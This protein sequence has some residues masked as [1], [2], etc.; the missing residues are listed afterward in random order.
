MG[1]R[2]PRLDAYIARQN[3]FAKPILDHLR[4]VVHAACPDVEETMK[5]SAPHFDY[6]GQMMCS[7]AAF[8]KHAVFGFW[9]SSLINGLGPNSANG[10]EAAGNM[11]RL[12]SVKDLPSRREIAGFIRAAMKLNDEGIVVSKAAKAPK[13]EAKVPSELAAAEALEVREGLTCHGTTIHFTELS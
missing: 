3:D 5:W 2:D 12:T 8:K 9:K 7:M 10:G 11:G 1:I 6:K 13:P 4:D